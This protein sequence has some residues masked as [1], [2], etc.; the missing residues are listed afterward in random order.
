MNP[1]GN[2]HT[3]AQARQRDSLDKRQR[4]LTAL[5]SLEQQGEKVT[6]AAVARTAGVS[7][8]LTYAAGIREHIEA[9]QKRQQPAIPSPTDPRR[10]TTATL[11]TELHLARQEI[12]TLRH[13]KERIHHALQHQLGH[14]L[15]T[16]GTKHL[17]DRVDELTQDNQRLEDTLQR[18]TQ[19]NQTLRTRVTELETDLAAARTSLRRMIR[20]E[21][22]NQ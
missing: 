16:M 6:F 14:Q 11:R 17:S 4:A 15:D 9:A 19:E 18:A 3:L 20:K 7:T 13:G 2:P 8:W 5:V 12:Q 1:R 22:T 21:N 10:S